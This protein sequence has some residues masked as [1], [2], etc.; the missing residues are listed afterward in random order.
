MQVVISQLTK[1]VLMHKVMSHSLGS[2][3][4]PLPTDSSHQIQHSALLLF[5][6][7]NSKPTVSCQAGFLA[8]EKD[9]SI[10]KFYQG[11]VT[12]QREEIKKLEKQLRSAKT[13]NTELKCEVS[14][15]QHSPTLKHEPQLTVIHNT[16]DEILDS[17][18]DEADGDFY[19]IDSEEE[20]EQVYYK[21]PGSNKRTRMDIPCG[22]SESLAISQ[23]FKLEQSTLVQWQGEWFATAKSFESRSN[24]K[25]VATMYEKERSLKPSFLIERDD[26]KRLKGENTNVP[27]FVR[28]V[29]LYSLDFVR[30]AQES[31]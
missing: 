30:F 21:K 3:S 15:L 31:V 19:H 8:E 12:R 26:L 20:A 28:Y 23:E 7:S 4:A 25:K 2:F 16:V 22:S 24:I 10:I 11:I 17:D 1:K 6:M 13:E 14:R 18:D 9:D 5:E 27:R 29:Y